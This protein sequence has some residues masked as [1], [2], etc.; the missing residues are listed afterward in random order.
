[1][2]T[3]VPTA[4]ATRNRPAP[5][6][7]RPRR[8]QAKPLRRTASDVHGDAPAFVAHVAEGDDARPTLRT[9]AV[10]HLRIELLDLVE[11][12]RVAGAREGRLPGLV[13]ALQVALVVA[14]GYLALSR[15]LRL[16][17]GH[18]RELREIGR[19]VRSDGV[20][21]TGDGSDA[22]G[23]L[24]AGRVAQKVGR[25]QSQRD[26]QDYTGDRR[27]AAPLPS[28]GCGRHGAEPYTN[29][30]G[31]PSAATFNVGS[32][33]PARASRL[34]WLDQGKREAARR[35]PLARYVP[36]PRTTSSAP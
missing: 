8:C 16:R 9:A 31:G 2:Q 35:R 29:L 21:R 30:F 5:T 24:P 23:F 26:E 1:M 11:G 10:R 19:K 6:L 27:P 12:D 17:V 36:A 20:A 15:C 18:G 28:R 25:T 14:V 4:T 32:I 13:C 33:D 22:L 3:A 7:V 34:S